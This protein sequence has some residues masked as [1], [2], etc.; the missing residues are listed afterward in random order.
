VVICHRRENGDRADRL[1]AQARGGGR[2]SL[3]KHF[4]AGELHRPACPSAPL[5]RAELQAQFCSFVDDE[6]ERSGTGVLEATRR[7]GLRTGRAG[8]G[9]GGSPRA[10]IAEHVVRGDLSSTLMMPPKARRLRAMLET[11]PFREGSETRTN[12]VVVS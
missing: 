4:A 3:A 8:G 2:T 10:G 12:P 7:G 9:G 6:E 1:G 11:S 5:R